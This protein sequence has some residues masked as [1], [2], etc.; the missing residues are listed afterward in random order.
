MDVYFMKC[1]GKKRARNTNLV[2]P[3]SPE[4]GSSDMYFKAIISSNSNKTIYVHE[5]I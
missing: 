3:M 1:L 4:I 2:V 5:Y